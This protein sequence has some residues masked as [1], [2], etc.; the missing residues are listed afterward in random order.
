MRSSA[1]PNSNIELSQ[2]T[3]E[4]GIG[5]IDGGAVGPPL[6]LMAVP[7]RDS[8]GPAEACIALAGTVVV[9]WPLPDVPA[10]LPR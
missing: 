6:A 10:R 9:R 2:I 3:A 5:L 8:K 4:L 7:A 1:P